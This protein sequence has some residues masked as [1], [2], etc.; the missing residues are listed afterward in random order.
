MKLTKSKLQEIIKEELENFSEKFKTSNNK[1][2]KTQ[3]KVV[4]KATPKTNT[5]AG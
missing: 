5:D 2:V 3:P 4:T 1:E